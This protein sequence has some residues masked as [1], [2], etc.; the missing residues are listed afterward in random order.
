MLCGPGHPFPGVRGPGFL[1]SGPPAGDFPLLE[2]HHPR[3]TPFLDSLAGGDSLYPTSLLLLIMEPFRALGWKLVSMSLLPASSPTDG[4]GPWAGPG[5]RPS[6]A[7]L[8]YLLA[9]FM[10]TLV[11]PGHDGKLFV[12]ALTPLLFWATER[13]LTGG[14]L[15]AFGRDVPGHR[16]R[17]PH[18]PLPAGLLP[19]RGRGVYAA[20][21]AFLLWR[22]G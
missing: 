9:P 13:A 15:R 18:H 12:T 3:G 20:V 7:G 8:A 2:P 4:S 21:R 11:Y 5:R 19:F 1:R 14:R 17:H 6:C 16:P 10:V 22:A